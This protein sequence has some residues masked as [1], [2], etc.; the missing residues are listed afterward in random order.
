MLKAYYQTSKILTSGKERRGRKRLS[1][2]FL[3]QFLQIY[4]IYF[5]GPDAYIRRIYGDALLMS[6]I[7]L[8]SANS[9]SGNPYHCVS[10]EGNVWNNSISRSYR[11]APF[12]NYFFSGTDNG[13]V[14]GRDDIEVTSIDHK[15]GNQIEHGFTTN[16]MSYLGMFF[17]TEIVVANPIATY[18]FERLFQNNSGLDIVVKEIGVYCRTYTNTDAAYDFC[19]VRDVIAPVTVSTGE[20]FKVK[21]TFQV[22]V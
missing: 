16:T 7:Y 4:N 15:L 14:I 22:S 2:S 8:T 19:I 11:D 5:G 18:N 13:I 21:Y 6:S 3:K 12:M 10:G 17:D 1:H 9:N 20:Y